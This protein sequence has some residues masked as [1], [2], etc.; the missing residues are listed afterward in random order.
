MDIEILKATAKQMVATGKGILAADESAA[1]CQKRFDSVGVPCTEES[2]RAYREMIIT[3]PGLEEYI[4]GIILHDE[5]L[6]QKTADGVPFAEV[7]SKK[8]I[9][10]GIKVDAGPKDLALHPGEKVTEGLDGL[11]E[12]LAEY[13]AL[14][15]RFA[16][17]RAVISIDASIPSDACI[18]V[19]A[20]ALARYAALCQEAD[21][22]PMIEPEILISGDQTIERSYEVTLAS[23]KKVFEELAVQNVLLEGVI[24]KTSMV[25][26]GTKATTQSNVTQVAEATLRCLKEH[27][28]AH[29]GGI[30]FLSGG[31][32]DEQ[33]T[34]HLNAMNAAGSLP[35]PLSFSYARAIQNPALKVWAQNPA[36]NIASAQQVLLFRS[37]MNSLASQG[38]YS[39]A[40]E[41]ERSY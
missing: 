28:P 8:G 21:I 5:T 37:K 22:V 26:A 25:I 12:R 15:A 18:H 34:A 19:N 36:T 33:A 30:V 14:G 2:R 11:R 10:P 7:L 23:L 4:S 29:I 20:H 3:A 40:M 24:L 9:L 6:R 13:K 39:D 35:W 38:K 27:V 31:Q 32:A 16:K 1:T 41:T 17:W